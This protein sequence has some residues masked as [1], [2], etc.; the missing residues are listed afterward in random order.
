[1]RDIRSARFMT[2]RVERA[3]AVLKKHAP[4]A[5]DWID[6]R[7]YWL[8]WSDITKTL[9]G[10]DDR[11]KR[12]RMEAAAIAWRQQAVNSMNAGGTTF[13]P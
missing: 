2:P 10:G 1:M 7:A 13:K 9:V 11:A 4:Q 5:S 3:I 6:D 12:N 8:E